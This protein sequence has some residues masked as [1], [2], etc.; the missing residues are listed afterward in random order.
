MPE[1]NK[2]IFLDETYTNPS[3]IYRTSDMTLSEDNTASVIRSSI[4]TGNNA[5][6]MRNTYRYLS[7]QDRDKELTE[8]L[9]RDHPTVK[10]VNFEIQ[11]LDSLT[12]E[13]KYDYEYT[14][15]N[16]T[17][18]AGKYYFMKIPWSDDRKSTEAISYDTREYPYIHWAYSDF[19]DEE[20]SIHLPS[21]YHPVDLQEH[22]EYSCFA[23]KYTLD[24]TFSD[25]I[26][27][28]SRTLDVYEK[29]IP[30]E[31][32]LEFKEFYSNIVKS[33]EMQILLETK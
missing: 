16:Y 26:L 15:Q 17:T 33:D 23:G 1:S 31:N 11:N 4:K 22:T 29:D 20:I 19:S 25:N 12:Y 28:C 8:V 9:V 3:E 6:S 24:F 10:L 7:Q 14:V 32:Y 18:K 21:D 5:A 2:L 27:K 30:P 13:L